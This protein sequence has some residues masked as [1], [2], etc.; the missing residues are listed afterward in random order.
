MDDFVNESSQ[1]GIYDLPIMIRWGG[2][3]RIKNY[4]I[5]YKSSIYV[6]IDKGV[7][8]TYLWNEIDAFC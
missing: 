8:Y 6:N 5:G 1:Q 3:L 4:S 7:S 2:R